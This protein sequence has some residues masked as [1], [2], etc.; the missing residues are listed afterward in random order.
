MTSKE[1]MTCRR[2]IVF[3]SHAWD[4]DEC[5]RPTHA[6]VGQLARALRAQSV[7]AWFDEEQMVAGDDLDVAMSAGIEA[8][9]A[10]CVCLTRAYCTKVDERDSNCRREFSCAMAARKRI[11]PLILEPS[12]RDAGAWPPGVVRMTLSRTLWIDASDAGDDWSTPAQRVHAALQTRRPA[13]AATRPPP[14]RARAPPAL[15]KV[16]WYI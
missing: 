12:M 4:A 1:A 5:G 10:V 15:P 6:R 11:I 7:D 14:R 9:D 8:A 16:E 2:P 13:D 3:L